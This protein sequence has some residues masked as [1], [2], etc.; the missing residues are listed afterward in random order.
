MRYHLNKPGLFKRHYVISDQSGAERYRIDTTMFGNT[1]N[2]RNN[3][4]D[5]LIEIVDHRFK[6]YEFVRNGQTLA[7]MPMRFFRRLSHA[8]LPNGRN[9]NITRNIWG[10][11]CVLSDESGELA[12]ARRPLFSASKIGHIDLPEGED[13][14]LLL[15]IYIAVDIELNR[16]SGE[17]G[18]AV[19]V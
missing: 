15:A 6:G 1:Y 18:P 10:T 17:S 4:G 7:R 11:R 8:E 9:I 19:N 5:T 2:L 12:T 16:G 3:E 13:E 14:L